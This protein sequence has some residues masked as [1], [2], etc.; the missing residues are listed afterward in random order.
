MNDVKCESEAITL[1]KLL[2]YRSIL[3]ISIADVMVL[4]SENLKT[5]GVTLDS[6]LTFPC[7][8]SSV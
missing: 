6:H 5:L 4:L 2:N 3:D 7:H 8:V 1:H